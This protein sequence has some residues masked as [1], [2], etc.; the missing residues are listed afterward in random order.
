MK[1]VEVTRQEGGEWLP[2]ENGN[3]SFAPGCGGAVHSIKFDN[4][5]IWDTVSGWRRDVRIRVKM[6]RADA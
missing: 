5:M 1:A 6:G 3:Y 4:G 2:F